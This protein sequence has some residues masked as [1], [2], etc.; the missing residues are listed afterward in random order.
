MSLQTRESTNVHGLRFIESAPFRDERGSFVRTF[1]ADEYRFEVENGTPL[2]FLEDDMS[3]SRRNV[4]RGLHGDANTWK[5]IHCAHGHLFMAVADMRSK[6]PTYLKIDCF[7][8][9]GGSG[10]QALIPAG[11][12]TGMACLS[13]IGVLSYK[14][15]TRYGGAA[16]QFTVRWDDAQLGIHWP[17]SNPILSERDANADRL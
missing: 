2:I 8:L 12:A 4:V 15:T 14:Q 11:C 6:S 16:R 17:V 9:H 5:L 13:E 3:T 7:E 10:M 1:D